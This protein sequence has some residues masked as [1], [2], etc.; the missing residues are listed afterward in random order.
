MHDNVLLISHKAKQKELEIPFDARAFLKDSSIGEDE[1]P[2]AASF[3]AA[4][5]RLVLPKV[6]PATAPGYCSTYLPFGTPQAVLA[7]W[8]GV[9][10]EGGEIVRLTSI[11]VPSG[12]M[13]KH[14]EEIAWSRHTPRTRCLV[15]GPTHRYNPKLRNS[16]GGWEAAEDTSQCPEEIEFFYRE[17]Q[18]HWC[19]LG[20]FR[21]I[22]R[23][24]RSV[25]DLGNTV[26]EV[27][28]PEDEI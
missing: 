9:Y 5:T 14:G 19:Y 25:Q 17:N 15:M 13:A 16:K 10:L 8:Y 23:D 2:R 7:I 26:Q 3:P 1:I 22:G 24:V 20:T 18:T 28:S 4:N 27:S 12:Y 21:C 6:G 11:S